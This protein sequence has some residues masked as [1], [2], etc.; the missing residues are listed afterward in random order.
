MDDY[1]DY[2]NNDDNDDDSYD[3]YDGDDCDDDDDDDESD[4][5]DDDDNDNDDDDKAIPV[6]EENLNDT[7]ELGGLRHR[8]VEHGV[9]AVTPAEDI[10][11][12]AGRGGMW[13]I[14]IGY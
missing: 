7:A 12:R 13:N 4:D 3:E 6:V 1:N 14:I 5:N 2:D 10:F 9:P 11:R 8:L